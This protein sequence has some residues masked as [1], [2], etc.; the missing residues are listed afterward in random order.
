[1]FY[2]DELTRVWVEVPGGDVN[3]NKI[4]V[5][6][7][8]FTKY[9]VFAV[10]GHDDAAGGAQT[11]AF[12]DIAGHW[13]EAGIKQAAAAGIVSGYP[14]GAFKPNG[15]VTRAEFA[16]MLMNALKPQDGEAEQQLTFS[17]NAKIGE[18]ARKALAQAVYAGIMKGA[19]DNTLRPDALVTRAEMATMIARALGRSAEATAATGFA[20]DS[21][22]PDWAKGAVTAMKELGIVNGKGGGLVRS[23]RQA[24][25]SGS[26]HGSAE[27]V[28]YSKQV[29]K[30]NP[31]ANG[32]QSGSDFQPRDS[33][34]DQTRSGTRR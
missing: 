25:A 27:N 31:A 26:G 20:D 24:D 9:A 18:W 34:C 29:I 10:G 3:G 4:S 33:A 32:M 16:V 12:T 5:K 21:R 15:S 2:Y 11:D 30:R 17:D 7:N 23:R 8:H 1:M 6:V 28:D 19:D 14:N 22:I 13:A